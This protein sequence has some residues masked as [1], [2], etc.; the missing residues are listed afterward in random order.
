MS[1]AVLI[2]FNQKNPLSLVDY[3]AVT[4]AFLQG[5]VFLDEIDL[6]PYDAPS[7]VVAALGRCALDCEGV[8]LVCDP[9]LLSS[10][11]AAVEAA[12]GEKFAEEYLLQAD[13]LYGVLPTGEAGAKLVPAVVQRIDAA[14]KQ[15]YR[16]VV[17]CAV[18]APHDKLFAALGR[19]NEAGGGTLNTHVTE[20]FGVQRI[21]IIY[22]ATT[23]KMRVDEAVR[24]LATELF[25]FLYATEDETPAERLFETLK[26]R[27]LRLSTAESFTGG[28]VGR[29]IVQIAGA[30]AVFY[31]GVNAYNEEAKTERLG[32]EASLLRNK[33][34]VS[35]DVAYQMA[36]GLLKTGHCDVAVSTTGYASPLPDGTPAGLC[37]IAVGTR[38]EVKVYRYRLT[39]DRENITETAVNLALFLAYHAAK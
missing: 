23:P 35:D 16:R 26:L 14:R 28:G 36:A 12:T 1:Y 39:G 6:L 11:K 27:R 8:F 13:R 25:E 21:E 20:R 32:V 10:G 31:E 9:V 15:S 34:A 24:I 5:G 2:L 37:Y 33:G 19:A 17:L 3:Q 22:D 38:A 7:R 30:S 29:A 18:C 4:D